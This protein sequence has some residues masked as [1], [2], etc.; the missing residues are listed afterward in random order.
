MYIIFVSISPMKSI[1]YVA[2]RLNGTCHK[3]WK[4]KS[5]C[6]NVLWLKSD[7]LRFFRKTIAKNDSLATTVHMDS[8]WTDCREILRRVLLLNYVDQMHVWL[9]LSRNSR[10]LHEK[11]PICMR[12]LRLH[13]SEITPHKCDS[14][15]GQLRKRCK[16][17]FNHVLLLYSWLQ[18]RNVM[19]LRWDWCGVME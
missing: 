4:K 8:L 14:H 12:S 11:K 13:H 2:L 7:V 3:F 1:L 6:F 18:L 16:H 15:A 10:L 9:K 17:S 5:L 19:P